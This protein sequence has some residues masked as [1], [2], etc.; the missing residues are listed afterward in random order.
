[1][2]N[3]ELAYQEEYR[4]AFVATNDSGKAHRSA[5]AKIKANYADPTKIKL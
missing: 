1:M 2:N 4:L 5:L 3:M